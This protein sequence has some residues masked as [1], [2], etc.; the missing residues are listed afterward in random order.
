MQE[1]TAQSRTTRLIAELWRKNQPQ[2]LERIDV[3]ESAAAAADS[4]TLSDVQRMEAESLAHKLAGSLGMFGFPAGTTLAR[5][6]EDEFH[7]ETPSPD[8]LNTLTRDLRAELFPAT[9]G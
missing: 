5:A 3:L 2:I 1:E 4:G 7:H 8:I 9:E 6:L